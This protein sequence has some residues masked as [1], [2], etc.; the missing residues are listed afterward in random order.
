VTKASLAAA[1]FC[2]A[3]PA[4]AAAPQPCPKLDPPEASDIGALPH[5]AA[6]LRPGG[7]LDIL[8]IGAGPETRQ[9]G[10]SG[11]SGATPGFF[12][13]L[14]RSLETGVRTLHA[15]VMV[16]GGRG[17]LAPAQLGLIRAA[18]AQHH[19]Q[20]VLWQTGTIDAVQAEPVEDFYQALADGADAASSAN[21]D[22]ILIEPQYSRFLEANADLGPYLSAMA[23]AG[24]APGSLVF[25]RHTLMHDWVDAGLIDL[26]YARTADRTA[27]A[28]RLHACLATALADLILA[29]SEATAAGK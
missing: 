17:M 13:Q 9:A 7:V 8:A 6:A 15:T 1:L 3:A 20:L 5:L 4:L 29:Q 22:L 25:H 12:N 23:A 14:T 18:L 10:L 21:A 24:A 16:R 26:E 28:A 27:V 19:Y 11:A 2:L